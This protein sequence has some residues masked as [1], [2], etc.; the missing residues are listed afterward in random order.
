MWL[1][2]NIA[3]DTSQNYTHRKGRKGYRIQ[4]QK[5]KILLEKKLGIIQ[6]LFIKNA[7]KLLKKREREK[8]A[9]C[10]SVWSNQKNKKQGLAY[11]FQK[12]LGVNGLNSPMKRFRLTHQIKTQ[13]NIHTCKTKPHWQMHTLTE[14]KKVE[15][16]T[17]SK[18]NLT[19]QISNQN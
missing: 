7:S 10:L 14:S 6:M 13:P 4:V 1:P 12:Y 11:I 16:D 8:N 9:E 18:R 15:N 17:A 5:T 3:K 2:D 19:K